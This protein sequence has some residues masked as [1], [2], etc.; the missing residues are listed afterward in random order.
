MSD[1][2]V[3]IHRCGAMR[4]VTA[5]TVLHKTKLKV[6]KTFYAM[7]LFCNSGTGVPAHFLSRHLGLSIP[8]AFRLGLRIRAQMA[9]VEDLHQIGGNGEEVFI[10]E[11]LMHGEPGPDSSRLTRTIVLGM[12]DR[13]RLLLFVLDNRKMETIIPIINARV[14]AGSLL[15]TDGYSSYKCLTALGWDH[16]VVNHSREWKN[17]DGFVHAPIDSVFRLVRRLFKVSHFHVSQKYLWLY[18]KEIEFRFNRR[19]TGDTAFANL[20]GA[21][22]RATPEAMLDLKLNTDRRTGTASQGGIPSLGRG[23]RAALPH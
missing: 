23:D 19:T 11:M 7:L 15:I 3:Y 8:G 13:K 16:S 9:L 12:R 17:S 4:S 6:H 14:R 10:D 20:I 2:R 22:P 5:E 1:P 21:F 18:L